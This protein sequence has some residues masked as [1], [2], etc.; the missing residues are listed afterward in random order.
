[1]MGA[2]SSG[3]PMTPVEA[4]KISAGLQLKQLGRR[5][6]HGLH[7][8]DAGLAGEGIGIAGIDDERRAPGLPA[9]LPA[10]QSTG[11]ERDFEVVK[12]PATVVPG[13]EHRQQHIGPVLVAD[14]GLGGRR[15][16]RRRSAAT[17]A[18][19][20]RRERR[21]HVR[22][23]LPAPGSAAIC[24]CCRPLVAPVSPLGRRIASASEPAPACFFCLVRLSRSLRASRANFLRSAIQISTLAA[25][26]Q[27]ARSFLR[28]LAHQH[29]LIAV[30]TWS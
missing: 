10:H 23:A 30:F 8:L 29:V 2:G 28:L 19:T 25:S 24:G 14:A 12:Q 4:W 17:Q 13:I 1:M 9:R 11:A 27:L 16:S 15:A 21:D 22:H 3:S 20:P 18:R 6:R 5:R 26:L 7:G